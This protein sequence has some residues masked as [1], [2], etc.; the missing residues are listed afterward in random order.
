M[1]LHALDLAPISG[2][3]YGE[4]LRTG[5][6]VVVVGYDGS[7]ASHQAVHYA[8]GRAGPK[9]RI[10]AVHAA[11][12][13][14]WWFGSPSYQPER[15][16]YRTAADALLTEVRG[17]VPDD[18]QLETSFVE[19][20]PPAALMRVAREQSAAEIVV[21]A[22]GS[23]PSTRGLGNVPLALLRGCDRPVVV[24]PCGESGA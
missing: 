4:H 7:P 5:S 20:S 16:D 21:G 10:V 2:G 17:Q 11:G 14:E 12:P 8:I 18:V 6:A 9:G 1:G 19:G 13:G 3:G 24:V 23:D 22:H 15:D